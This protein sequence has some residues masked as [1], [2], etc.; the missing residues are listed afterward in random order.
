M[1]KEV[2]KYVQN[3]EWRI[4]E[5]RVME[6]VHVWE[7]VLLVVEMEKKHEVEMEFVHGLEMKE[8]VMDYEVEKVV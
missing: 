1:E 5:V 8:V 2:E 7:M 6:T 4:P 3:L